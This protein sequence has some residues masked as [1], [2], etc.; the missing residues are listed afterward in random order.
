MATVIVHHT[1]CGG[2][3]DASALVDGP[4]YDADPH[5]VTG[6]ENVDNTSDV[7]KPVSTAQAAAD[8]A[9][10][11]AAA[12]ASNLTSGTV[13]LARFPGVPLVI[14]ATG[15]S[16]FVQRPSFSW[17]PAANLLVWNNSDL[18]G[19]VGTAFAA[20]P[21]T[22]INVTEKIASD[23]AYANPTRPVY[24]IHFSIGAM[25]VSHWM[26]AGPPSPDIYAGLIANVVPALA[27]ISV[28]KING[29]F[30]WQG[31]SQTARSPELF[32]ANWNTVI[33][34]FKLESWFDRATPIFFYGIAPSTISG[35]VATDTTNEAIQNIVNS[36]STVR[37]FINT[38]TL[39]ASLWADTLHGTAA[40]FAQAGL[41]GAN[42][43]L[44]R[45]TAQSVIST[46]NLAFNNATAARHANRNL[47]RGGDFT[48]NPWKNGT[49]FVSAADGTQIADGIFW[50]QSGVG[51]VDITRAT[52]APTIAQA[53]QYT[54]HSLTVDV[55]TADAAIANPDYYG[56]EI[57]IL[58][59]D[60]SFLGM[61]QTGAKGAVISFWVKST[62]TGDYY[63]S[64]A[65]SANNRSYN[66]RYTINVSD[67]WE[68]KRIVITGDTSGTW[69]Y[70][71]AGVG[72]RVFFTIACSDTYLFSPDTWN[73]GDV[74]VGEVIASRANGM[75]STANFFRL[76]L[77]QAEEGVFPSSFDRVRD[78]QM[79]RISDLPNTAIT[80]LTTSSSANLRA[81]VTDEVGTGALLFKGGQSWEYIETLTA[82]SSASLTTSAFT[83]TFD[84]YAFV[85]SNLTPATDGVSL[86]ATVESGGSFQA[87]TY[88]NATAPTTSI[89]ISTATLISNSA[90][91]GVSGTIFLTNVNSTSVNKILGGRLIVTTQT[92]LVP[93]S[94]NV[95]GYWNGGQGAVTRMRW[96]TSSGNL[97]A[98][99]IKV[100]G[101]RNS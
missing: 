13:P 52:D 91:K 95:S 66:S 10:A 29:L 57:D 60:V 47:I 49:S 98:G 97:G 15:Q 19:S 7:N 43:Y 23:I 6:L 33:D 3:A 16:N 83:S 9:V 5:I 39:E 82:S 1:P 58:G 101:I 76:A 36:D 26:A 12:N 41:L 78:V 62:I 30:I 21:S 75:S 25:D 45:E 64:A 24:L 34:R 72:M 80:F 37:K 18:D 96:Q 94:V 48:V 8:A 56:I 71:P 69:L 63:V 70:T 4:T 31:E 88:L 84:D 68:Y 42:A 79:S 17:T 73:A 74:R 40:G 85:F 54:Q 86:N 93:A 81:L 11:A 61:G 77:P 50:R 100:F 65:N 51:V 22:T 14:I 90:G 2:P 44:G 35:S 32:A 53:G 28:S 87:T 92:S 89:D 99:I 55:T 59:S 38:S 27:A 46:R 20:P 67:T